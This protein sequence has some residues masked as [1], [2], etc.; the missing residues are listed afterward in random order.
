MRLPPIECCLY[1]MFR[2]AEERFRPVRTPSGSMVNVPA[3][4]AELR[5][6]DPSHG[7]RDRLIAVRGGTSGKGL[8]QQPHE[9]NRRLAGTN[10]HANP[11]LSKSESMLMALLG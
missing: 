1:G 9:V 10:L 5:L 2:R 8:T 6:S 3:R 4:C 11:S 7:L